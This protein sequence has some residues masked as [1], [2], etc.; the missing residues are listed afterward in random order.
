MFCI[1]TYN[2]A[3]AAISVRRD[4]SMGSV[5]R[6]YVALASPLPVPDVPRSLSVSSS[7]S[8]ILPPFVYCSSWGGCYDHM[9]L[10]RSHGR[11]LV[12]H[13]DHTSYHSSGSLT[14]QAFLL[15]LHRSSS[16]N[17]MPYSAIIVYRGLCFPSHKTRE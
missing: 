5:R 2:V 11:S 7:P 1:F 14:P 8:P 17:L 13:V 6:G 4:F 9:G 16:A 12:G 10:V 15:E 3:T